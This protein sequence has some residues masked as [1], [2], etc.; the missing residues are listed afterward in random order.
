MTLFRGVALILLGISQLQF[1]SIAEACMALTQPKNPDNFLIG[2]EL[3]N[4]GVYCFGEDFHIK[5]IYTMGRRYSPYGHFVSIESSDVSVNLRNRVASTN[6]DLDAGIQTQHTVREDNK[7]IN[8]PKNIQ[9]SNGRLQLDARGLGIAIVGLGGVSGRGPVSTPSDLG[10]AKAAVL[11]FRSGETKE[12]IDKDVAEAVQGEKWEFERKRKFFPDPQDYTDRKIRIEKMTIRTKRVGIVV[13][14]GG[15]VIRDSV[16]EVDAG[17]AIWI[18]GPNALI[19]NNTII[20]RGVADPDKGL[21]MLDADAPIRLH[22][23]DGAIIRNNRIIVR[24]S[25]PQRGVSLFETGKVQIEN[26]RFF[27]VPKSEN[28]VQAFSGG[29]Q[30][31]LLGNTFEAFWKSYLP[32]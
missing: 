18:F 6:A 10:W 2:L 23:G 1:G 16:I 4:P 26:N 13:Q 8:P 32:F 20:V 24:G 30:S 7:I 25:A 15:T 17:T 14:G 11:A 9:I 22:H 31:A 12:T 21:Y 29:D 5:G 28:A 3:V 27:G 19:E